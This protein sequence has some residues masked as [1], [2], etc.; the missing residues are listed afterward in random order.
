M[1]SIWGEIQ[2]LGCLVA[3]CQ[4]R[5]F[6][7]LLTEKCFTVFDQSQAA[8]FTS[9][10]VSHFC[11][12]GNFLLSFLL[13]YA[14]KILVKS[15]GG[16]TFLSLAPSVR[17]WQAYFFNGKLNVLAFIFLI[18]LQ[19]FWTWFSQKLAKTPKIYIFFLD[20]LI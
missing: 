7:C 3:S 14:F 18:C 1:K 2:L 13:W 11:F 5:N 15:R 10:G 19:Q 8:Q 6:L 12:S 16:G 20:I 4:L 17:D 9:H